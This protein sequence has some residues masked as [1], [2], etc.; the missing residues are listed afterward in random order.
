MIASLNPK[1]VPKRNTATKAEGG[2]ESDSPRRR[3]QE[4]VD[5]KREGRYDVEGDIGSKSDAR[6]P[7]GQDQSGINGSQA[8][9]Q[10]ADEAFDRGAGNA[11]RVLDLEQAMRQRQVGQQREGEGG[12]SHGQANDGEILHVPAI[13]VV[14]ADVVSGEGIRGA[15]DSDGDAY[16]GLG[17]STRYANE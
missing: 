13:R 4:E 9:V 8:P 3:E 17:L 2:Q 5:D 12:S 10:Q 15:D 16:A 1:P 14:A 6:R 7:V 11:E